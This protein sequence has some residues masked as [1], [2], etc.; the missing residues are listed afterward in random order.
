[1]VKLE[2]NSKRLMLLH[3]RGL[4][5][6][7]IAVYFNCNAETIRNRKKALGLFSNQGVTIN[8]VHIKQTAIKLETLQPLVEQG[9]SDY[10]IADIIGYD[11]RTIH[12]ARKFY[13]LERPS[14]IYSK[15]VGYTQR[16]LEI[17]IGH[18]LGDGHLRRDNANTTGRISQGI[19]QIPYT[20]W[21][22]KE[23]KPLCSDMVIYKRKTVD[24]R[25]GIYYSS[26]D[27][28]IYAN[29]ELNWMYDMFYSNG[30]KELSPSLPMC[31]SELSL[32]VWFMDDGFL[33]KS[34]GYY[35]ATQCFKHHHI[36]WQIF[37]KFNIE[38]TIPKSGMVYIKKRSAQHFANLVLPHMIPSMQYKLHRSHVTPLIQGKP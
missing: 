19:A 31:V 35:I 34:G 11:A 1:M 24:K 32:A 26:A 20:E 8:G 12:Q 3:T 7:K 36:L 6:S 37:K 21:K 28:S 30:Y 25:T 9:L 33:G 18:T 4:S 15:P 13:K 29:S 23:L 14:M 27:A 10:K 2:I 38:I 22:V 17:L 5:N 16:Q